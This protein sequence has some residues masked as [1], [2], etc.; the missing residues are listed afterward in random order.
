MRILV[1]NPE[2]DAMTRYLLCWSKK[3]IKEIEGRNEIFHLER[4]KAN[5]KK[6][7]GM[8]KK[9]DIDLVLLNGHGGDNFVLGHN[10]EVVVDCGNVGLL[11]GKVVHA[12]SCNSAKGLGEVAMDIGVKAYVGYDAPF[13]A[14][15]MN[16]KISNPLN[17]STAALFLDAAF[18][19]Q[20][21]LADGKNSVEAV[22]MGKKGYDR[23]IVK[24]LMSPVQSDND[25][26]VG[27]LLWDRD[28]LVTIGQ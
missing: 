9:K 27:L 26:F 25:Q 24:A 16:D 22:R 7:E 15:R 21:A 10:D 13:L 8:L 12:M 6:I 23:S 28:H 5:R 17:D 20:K 14:P 4:K 18:I 11:E 1:S 3:L 2:V 19:P